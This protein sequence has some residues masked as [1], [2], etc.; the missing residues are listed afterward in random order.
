[1]WYNRN[2]TNEKYG[3]LK[4]ESTKNDIWNLGKGVDTVDVMSLSLIL[5]QLLMRIE[6]LE[7]QVG[8]LRGELSGRDKEWE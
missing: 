6:T 7:E 4:M 3:E 1:L 5:N 8:E 2:S